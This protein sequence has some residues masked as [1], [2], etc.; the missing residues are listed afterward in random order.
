MHRKMDESLPI[1]I[2]NSDG[3]STT[4]LNGRFVYSQI[5]IDCI[6]RLQSNEYDRHELLQ[7]CRDRYQT[8]SIELQHLNDFEREYTPDKVLWWYTR[9]SFFYK[10]LNHALRT[11]DI[12]LI[13]LFRSFIFDIQQQLKINQFNRT[14][15]R[16]YR[17]QIMSDSELNQ[18]KQCQGQFISINAFFSTSQ[19]WLHSKFILGDQTSTITHNRILFEIEID[20]IVV[21]SKPFADISQFSDFKEE[22][23][24]LFMVGSIFY[25]RT[26]SMDDEH[27]WNV[28]LRFCNDN[29]HELQELLSYMKER[30]GYGPTN[31]RILGDVLWKMGKL[32]LAKKY[33]TRLCQE[34]PSNDHRLASLYEDLGNLASQQGDLDQ[35]LQWHDRSRTFKKQNSNPSTDCLDR[36]GSAY[37]NL[38]GGSS[39]DDSTELK[40]LTKACCVGVEVFW[41]RYLRAIRFIYD[42]IDEFYPKIYHGND[43][44]RP[45]KVFNE[46]FMLVDGENFQSV[47]LYVGQAEDDEYEG[48]IIVDD[49]YISFITGIQFHTTNERT[50]RLYGM[51]DENEYTE[52]F[53]GYVLGY[54]RGRSGL[55][56]DEFQFIWYKQNEAIW[57]DSQYGYIPTDAVIAG[58]ENDRSVYIVRF[59]T[60]EG[61]MIFG[62]L[63][64]GKSIAVGPYRGVRTSSIYQI[65]INPKQERAFHWITIDVHGIPSNALRIDNDYVARF[66]H[67]SGSILL[68]KFNGNV[69]TLVYV[70]DDQEKE[71]EVTQGFQ[72]L[73]V[74]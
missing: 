36:I 69:Q 33:F 24:V 30:T 31:L 41:K 58:K 22:E 9:E 63:I 23:E 16:V 7:F 40:L 38:E 67:P 34:L 13:Y 62:K 66:I 25:V 15:S 50:T 54:V 11:Q 70:D 55:A 53:D 8:N 29:E 74:E 20:S 51:K 18:L 72:I 1:D 46:K 42:R 27:I 52:S 71:K 39:F 45:N 47:T 14:I 49:E 4:G 37:G 2:Y 65:L 56:I 19:S 73:C 28:K 57:K 12:H 60:K 26:I 68:G 64:Q 44:H 48:A 32:E 17:G 61:Q 21:E 35:S 43:D 10:I 5:L 3:Q 59:K 6:L